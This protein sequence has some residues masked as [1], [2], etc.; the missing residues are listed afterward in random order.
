MKLNWT[1]LALFLSLSAYGAT[2][3]ATQDGMTDE[4]FVSSFKEVINNEINEL[5]VNRSPAIE[6]PATDQ[7]VGDNAPLYSDLENRE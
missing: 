1:L 7:P 5:R 6:G 3:D 4:E 2:P